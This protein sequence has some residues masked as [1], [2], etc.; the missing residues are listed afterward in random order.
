MNE[1]NKIRM[2]YAGAIGLLCECSTEVSKE[3]REL[4]NDAVDDWCKITG[5]RKKI[6]FNR[7]EVLLPKEELAEKN[8]ENKNVS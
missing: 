1:F 3:T 7:I 4:I 6:I 8:K 2:Q 5:W